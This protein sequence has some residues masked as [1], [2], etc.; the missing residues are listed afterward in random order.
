MFIQRIDIYA[1]VWYI[2]IIV[3]LNGHW[4]FI[5]C[6][7]YSFYGGTFMKLKK[8]AAMLLCLLTFSA[9]MTGCAD[10]EN[11]PE[12]DEPKIQYGEDDVAK[13]AVYTK[14]SSEGYS[15]YIAESVHMAVSFDGKT[16]EP[17]FYDYG[18]LFSECEFSDLDG[19]VSTGVLDPQIYLDGDEYVIY[20]KEYTRGKT[21]LGDYGTEIKLND[22]GKYVVYHG[23]TS[24]TDGARVD[25]IRRV[26][27]S[28]DGSPVLDMT[29]EQDLP[30]EEQAV[31]ITVIVE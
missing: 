20:A 12:Q 5:F 31:T 23:H 29:A 24:L 7:Y 14:E 6:Y 13:L 9:C 26:H 25:G 30:T 16:Y 18:M 28:A 4:R 11:P 19:I 17:L 22:T 21:D 15:S 10:E 27:F 3:K 1:Y 8:I 2:C